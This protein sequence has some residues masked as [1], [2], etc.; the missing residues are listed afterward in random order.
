MQDVLGAHGASASVAETIVAQLAQ[1]V[2]LGLLRERM[3]HDR[4]ELALLNIACAN[5]RR[6]S[7]GLVICLFV[8]QLGSFFSKSSA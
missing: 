2:E 4:V 7:S 8:L 5:Y 6:G 1:A 3:L